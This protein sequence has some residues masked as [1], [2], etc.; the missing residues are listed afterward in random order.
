MQFSAVADGEYL[1]LADF[2]A[3]LLSCYP[4]KH[5]ISGETAEKNLGWLAT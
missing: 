4:Y 1:Q 3:F 2:K 5:G